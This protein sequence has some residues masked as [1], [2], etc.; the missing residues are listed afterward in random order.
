M[1]K[2]LITVFLIFQFNFCFASDIDTSKTKS[3]IITEIDFAGIFRTAA[4]EKNYVELYKYTDSTVI[5]KFGYRDVGEVIEKNTVINVIQLYEQSFSPDSVQ[6]YIVYNPDEPTVKHYLLEF[7][8][9]NNQ[10]RRNDIYY[11]DFTILN[12]KII[13]ITIIL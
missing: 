9:F 5:L 8:K 11:C 2:L 6:Y 13:I 4:I 7:Q 10:T 12:K 1:K 3:V